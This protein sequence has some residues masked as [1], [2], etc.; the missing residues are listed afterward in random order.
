M[1]TKVINKLKL[2]PFMSGS[3]IQQYHVAEE[4]MMHA[5]NHGYTHWYIDGA[6]EQDAPRNW[7]DERIE[8]LREKM[9]ELN[10]KPVYHGNFKAPLA[11]DVVEIRRAAQKFLRDEIDLAA[12]LGAPLILHGGGIVEPRYVKQA[13]SEALDGYVETVS[14]AKAYADEV[15][16]ELW[17]ENL[18]NYQRFHPFYYVFTNIH[19]YRYVLDRVPGVKM[20]FD[21]CHESVGGGDPVAVFN[22]IHDRV[23]AFSFSDTDGERD[24]HWPLGMGTIDFQGLIDA[25][26]KNN[27][28]GP[29]AFETRDVEPTENINYVNELFENSSS[30][31]VAV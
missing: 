1:K 22:E 5:Y 24:S 23:A 10:V 28:E 21:V 4:G 16:C 2:P 11:S 13:L 7:S 25:V 3:V 20:L 17:L 26:V 27:W 15:G 6:N 19:H 31:S 9:A 18:S 8:K 30:L 12:K 29:I 14:E